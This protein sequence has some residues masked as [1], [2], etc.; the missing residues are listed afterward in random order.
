M[1]NKYFEKKAKKYQKYYLEAKQS[2]FR[3]CGELRIRFTMLESMAARL[4]RNKITLRCIE[5]SDSC[6]I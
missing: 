4:H 5:N 3:A 2:E 6:K 1:I